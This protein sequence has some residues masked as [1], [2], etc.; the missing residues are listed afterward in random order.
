MSGKVAGL[1]PDRVIEIFHLLNPSGHTMA[2]RS[3]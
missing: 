3:I 2:Q 1:I